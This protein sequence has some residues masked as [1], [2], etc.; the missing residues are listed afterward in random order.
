MGGWGGRM[1]LE[2]LMRRGI[3]FVSLKRKRG[4]GGDGRG[5]EQRPGAGV[6]GA[7]GGLTWEQQRL[8]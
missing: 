7:A 5:R 8:R 1:R 4:I 6:W 3:K 2:L